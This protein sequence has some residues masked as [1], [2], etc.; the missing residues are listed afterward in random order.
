MP[1]VLVTNAFVPGHPMFVT[2]GEVYCGASKEAARS[3]F[4]IHLVLF[5]FFPICCLILGK[6]PSH[7][8]SLSTV[9]KICLCVTSAAD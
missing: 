1:P 4:H 3:F 7:V 6:L 5:D 2:R 8:A 9:N